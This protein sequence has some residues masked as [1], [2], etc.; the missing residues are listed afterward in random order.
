MIKRIPCD[1]LTKENF[2]YLMEAAWNISHKTDADVFV[3]YSPHIKSV[4]YSVHLNGWN[5]SHNAD[6]MFEA[7]EDYDY[8]LTSLDNTKDVLGIFTRDGGSDEDDNP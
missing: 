1:K 4:Q 2:L 5:A 3:L 8:C 7:R 6:Y